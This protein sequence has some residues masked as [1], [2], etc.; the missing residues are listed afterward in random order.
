MKYSING[1]EPGDFVGDSH[2]V[3]IVFV[4]ETFNEE[5]NIYKRFI[6]MNNGRS[7]IMGILGIMFHDQLV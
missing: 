6:E 1:N 5:N 7:A 4:W 3:S 2:H